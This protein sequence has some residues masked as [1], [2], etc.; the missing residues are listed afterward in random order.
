MIQNVDNSLL[1]K[2]ILF[3]TIFTSLNFAEYFESR[4]HEFPEAKSN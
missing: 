3:C 1:S 2:I 4:N